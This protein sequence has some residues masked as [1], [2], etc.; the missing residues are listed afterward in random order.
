MV[1]LFCRIV[2]RFFLWVYMIRMF[3]IYISSRKGV[4]FL[5]LSSI[6]NIWQEI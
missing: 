6:S 4:D 1:E 5:I 3:L 2:G